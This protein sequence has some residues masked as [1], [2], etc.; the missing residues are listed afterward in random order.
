MAVVINTNQSASFASLNL[1]KSSDLLQK[2]LSRLSSG[3][4]IANP[5]DDAGGLAVSMK[6]AAAIKRTDDTAINVSNALSFL[7]TQAGSLKS[8]SSVLDR[9]SELATLAGDVTKAPTD[10]SNYNTE[11][12]NLLSEL[13]KLSADQFNGINL[14]SSAA[15]SLTVY[16]SQDGTQ[17]MT[18]DQATLTN[19]Y[20]GVS[21]G[22]TA[23]TG[24]TISV[25]TDAIQT[26][27]TL[28]AS[29][30]AQSSRLQFALDSL[31]VNKVN[32]EAANSRIYDVD[33]AAE[34]TKLARANIL[35]QSGAS[36]LTQANAASQIALKLLQ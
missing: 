16:L 1:T 11:F 17:S 21:A 24:N 5:A 34:T 18:I 35:V 28:M 32:L 15:A 26:L 10:I 2:S 8:A 12:T 13:S 33:V 22:L 29:N 30:G 27:A 9:L 6:L 19:T 31:N 20:S 25:V 4:R 23:V 7:Q 3:S 14:F 36:M